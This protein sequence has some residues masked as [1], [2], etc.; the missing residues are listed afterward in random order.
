MVVAH[1]KG[2]EIT[3]TTDKWETRQEACDDASESP[4]YTT[5]YSYWGAGY[6]GIEPNVSVTYTNTEETTPLD[7][8]GLYY[9]I[10]KIN[11]TTGKFSGIFDGNGVLNSTARC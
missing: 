6:D 1:Y 9:G 2:E 7:S 10:Y 4:A 3:I 11:G 8:S 5:E